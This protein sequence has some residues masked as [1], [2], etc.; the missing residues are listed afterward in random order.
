MNVQEIDAATSSKIQA[1]YKPLAD[2]QH[3]GPFCVDGRTGAVTAG[4]P[5][6]DSLYVQAIGGSLLFAVL[7]HLLE[8]RTGDFNTTW[9]EVRKKLSESGY[10]VGVH[11]GS[12]RSETGSDCGFADNLPKIVA[13]LNAAQADIRSIIEGA[14][15]PFND[16]QAEI[17]QAVVDQAK[18]GENLPGFVSGEKLVGG[19]ETSNGSVQTLDGDHAEVA[20]AVNLAEGTTLDTAGLIK[21]GL[22]SFNLD[23]WYVLKVAEEVFALNKDQVM[24]AALGLYV[25][26]EMVLVE[27]KKN[28]RLP[29]II[30]S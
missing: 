13:R 20:A 12:H 16:E 1:A 5:R 2:W 24:P 26:T 17:W 30:H 15:Q 28:Y 21:E 14:T 18:T 9:E 27:D 22:Q 10:S 4:T 6:E 7:V 23:L 29:V 3:A 19:A 25:A 11:R 8:E